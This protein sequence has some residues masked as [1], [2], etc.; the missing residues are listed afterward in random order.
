M[1][2]LYA[3]VGLLAVV[4]G[5]DG[6]DGWLR[7]SRLPD[8]LLTDENL[9]STPRVIVTL[10][11]TSG[12][13]L[14]TAAK[15]LQTGIQGILGLDLSTDSNSST[16]EA[17]R[18]IIL[19]T[20]DSYD[21]LRSENSISVTKLDGLI[22]DGF[23]LSNIGENVYI[24]GS[25]ERGALYGAFEY[26]SMLAQGN[27]NKVDYITNPDAP[28]RWGNQWDNLWD[29]GTHGSIER[30][31][32]GDSIFFD[33]VGYVREDLSRVPL[34]GRLLASV[35]INGLIINNVNAD[36]TILSD[37]N[38]EGVQRVADLLRPWGVQI[39]LSLNFAS[40]K[41]FGGLETFDPLDKGVINWWQDISDSLFK[42]IP[43]FLGYLVK[44]SSED[45]P[46]PLSY[47]RTLAEGA[48]MFARSVQPYGGLVL[49][50]A[51]VYNHH[52]DWN[53][54]YADRAKAAV[55][56]FG[57]L[58]GKFDDNVV[59]QIKYGPIDFQVREAVSPLLSNLTQ[60]N[61]AI[62]LQITQE[63]LGQQCH[64]VY[65]APLW[66]DVLGFD[67]RVDGKESYV[68]DILSGKVFE[69]P[70][71]GYTAVINAGMDSTWM[72][73]HLSM[74]NFYAFGRLAW[75]PKLDSAE[76]LEDW[77]RL[78]FGLDDNIREVITTMSMKSWTAYENYSGNLGIQTLTDILGLH[79]GPNPA[80]QDNNGWGQWTRADHKTIGMD[81]T[82]WNGT[83]YTGQY[84][85]EVAQMYENIETTPDNL[86]LWFHHVPYTFK[87]HSGKTVI[88]HFYDSHYDGAE[89]VS[90]FH[91][92]WESLK[93]IID[94]ERYE[95]QLYRLKYQAGHS[96]VW[97]DAI[98]E[99]YR[100]L[101]GI[102]DEA[103][104]VRNHPW[105]IEAENMTLSGYQP[106]SV[107][108]FETASKYTAIVTNATGTATA[109][110]PFED[111]VYN[112]AINYFDTPKGKSTYDVSINGHIV[113]RWVGD[114][115]DHL[116]KVGSE[117][118][119][120]DSAIRITFENITVS[121]GDRLQIRGVTDEGEQA[122]LDYVSLLP[123]GVVD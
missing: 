81:R 89:T 32:G 64:L 66:Q 26:L 50:R 5:E 18:S 12:G 75:D 6:L 51:F 101:S 108:P 17:S 94:E 53:D 71:S 59:I 28:I 117:Y 22:K 112:L 13:P 25:N 67:M 114:A 27:F 57:G 8:S 23:Y 98:N 49:F 60:T 30:G 39:G 86:L 38:Q 24:I 34:F 1:K 14:E 76:I 95:K 77:T 82:M 83:G 16:W 87:L 123:Q 110:I 85:D 97:R 11:A 90:H 84:H 109:E 65:L 113:G 93:G 73:S 4:R 78:T 119:D 40:P 7:Y 58:D 70:L 36:A 80:S 55:E 72:G 45:Q 43:D 15:E 63:Y 62:E 29:N 41:D 54:W 74:S 42:R 106:V 88:Q 107:T 35:R 121:K 10:N 103:G 104:R 3:F 9:D 120:G 47:N 100:N 91:K 111:G 31:Y 69:R 105:R 52:S 122:P 68:R 99:F 56:F 2:P 116:G 102:P 44:A 33:G 92:A 115:E 21:N 61:T 118:L 37:R 48:N 96:I 19:S 20:A 46:G 79:Y